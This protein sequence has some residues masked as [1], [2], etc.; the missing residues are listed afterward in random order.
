[1]I[2]CCECV[3]VGMSL[4]GREVATTDGMCIPHEGCLIYFV[5][6]NIMVQTLCIQIWIMHGSCRQSLSSHCSMC[7]LW[8]LSADHSAEASEG[9]PGGGDRPG[10]GT[11]QLWGVWGERPW[12]PTAALWRL[13]CRVRHKLHTPPDLSWIFHDEFL[14]VWHRQI[15]I[16]PS[17]H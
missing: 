5:A 11:D 2:S 15:R 17:G 7:I 14:I 10:A 6:K 13:W 1:M 4:R 12:R 8:W 3:G 16:H 9:G